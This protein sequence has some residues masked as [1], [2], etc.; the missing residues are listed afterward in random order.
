LDD[1]LG[2][3][4]AA[5]AAEVTARH[6]GVPMDT[7]PNIRVTGT[8]LAGALIT[9]LLAQQVGLFSIVMGAAPILVGLGLLV[10][11]TSLRRRARA[12][13]A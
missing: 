8:A 6:I 10:L 12:S 9:S 1:Q 2:S 4:L 7:P 13:A 5:F 3:D 11:T